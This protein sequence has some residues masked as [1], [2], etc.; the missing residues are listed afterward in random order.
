MF[1][2]F[3][4]ILL[5][6]TLFAQ[7]VTML[8]NIGVGNQSGAYNTFFGI[9]SS[10]SIVFFPG[11]PTESTGAELYKS[12][13][14]EEGTGLVTEIF[15]GSSSCFRTDELQMIVINNKLLFP[16]RDNGTDVELWVSDGS[17]NGTF[18]LADINPGSTGSQPNLFS[19]PDGR[20]AFFR[21]TA[22][23]QRQIWTTKGTPESTVQVSLSPQGIPEKYHDGYYYF[24]TFNSP[25]G[26]DIDRIYR[27]DTA[28]FTQEFVVD[29]DTTVGADRPVILGFTDTSMLC[30]AYYMNGWALYS[31]NLSSLQTSVVYQFNPENTV[32]AGP[33]YFFNIPGTDKYLFASTSTQFGR[34][35]WITDGTNSGTRMLKD[36]N[37]GAADGMAT[38]NPYFNV[39]DGIVY[40]TGFNPTVGFDLFRT[41]GTEAGTYNAYDFQIGSFGCTKTISGAGM[42][43]GGSRIVGNSPSFALHRWTGSTFLPLLNAEGEQLYV[44]IPTGPVIPTFF[45]TAMNDELYFVAR[46]DSYG[47]ELHKLRGTVTNVAGSENSAE[48]V[49]P[50][51]ANAELNI[52]T[53]KDIVRYEIIDLTGRLILSEMIQS[54][55][56]TIDVS[57]LQNGMYLLNKVARNGK[58]TSVKFIKN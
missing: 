9:Y 22:N 43:I 19:S 31:T 20:R 54:N 55:T 13:G 44:P 42:L 46:S 36:I 56:G 12:N 25:I 2:I 35:L 18:R 39:H 5:G 3:L 17:E 33:N 37:T 24:P 14:T 15:P 57:K 21:A 1:R 32:I 7:P 53:T 48:R 23:L 28:T 11:S 16:A 26:T 50:N 45:G 29:F 27:I 34:E 58:V 51:P 10:D 30:K 47:Y 49:Y 40:F 38:E 41:D 52:E 4:F 8:K 6:P